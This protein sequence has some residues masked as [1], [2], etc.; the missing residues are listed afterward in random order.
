MAGLISPSFLVYSEFS[1]SIILT[2]P[3]KKFYRGTPVRYK[4]GNA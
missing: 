2:L 4:T 1:L 3:G